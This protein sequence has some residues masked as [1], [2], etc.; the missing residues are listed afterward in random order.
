MCEFP[1]ARRPLL[2]L[3][4]ERFATPAQFVSKLGG[5]T[6]INKVLIANNGI[7]AVKFIRS[8]RIWA[9]EMFGNE[10][11]PCTCTCLSLSD[12]SFFCSTRSSS[13]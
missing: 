2:T 6:V 10:V 11:R 8:I 7:A 9:Y 12:A 3:F 5:T 1:G 13:R 4:A